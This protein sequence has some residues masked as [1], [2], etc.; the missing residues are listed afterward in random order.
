MTSAGTCPASIVLLAGVGAVS[1]ARPIIM[2]SVLPRRTTAPGSRTTRPVTGT[3]LTSV[4]FRLPR[5][6]TDSATG[7]G[8]SLRWRRDTPSSDSTSPSHSRPTSIARSTTTRRT[9]RPSSLI[10]MIGAPAIS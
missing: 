4:P 6:T 10:S 1:A 2:I 3:P 8:T 9:G 5:S 7:L